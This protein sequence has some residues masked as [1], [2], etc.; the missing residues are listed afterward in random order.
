M[1]KFIEK[2]KALLEDKEKEIAIQIDDS[3]SV[4][5]LKS[6]DVQPLINKLYNEYGNG[7]YTQCIG[8]YIN[9]RIE[10]VKAFIA[11]M[12][13]G[14]TIVGI[15]PESSN[16]ELKRII[17]DN[18]ILH[19]LS[20]SE[21]KEKISH[22]DN[23]T[24]LDEE[25]ELEKA[26]CEMAV[27]QYDDIAVISY[28]SGTTG[29]FSKGV[30]ISFKNIEY[31][32]EQYKSI[33]KLNN[34]SKIITAL[35]LWHNYAMFACLTSSIF[36]DAVIFL[37][38]KWNL[39]KFVFW[40]KEYKA[41]VFPGS[42]Y[43]YLDIINSQNDLRDLKSLKICDSGGDSLPV[44]CIKK[45]ENMTGAI[46]TEGYGLT[47][48]TSL[49]HFNYS[50]KERKVGSI[51]RAIP[52]VKCKILDLNN[53]ELGND[54]WGILWINGPMVF[55][56]YVNHERLTKQVLRDG[57]F[58]TGDVV[59]KDEEGYYYIAGRYSD[60]KSLKQEE[61]VI[62]DI[63]NC[64]YQCDGIFRVH[65]RKKYDKEIKMVSYDMYIQL[66]SDGKREVVYDF[67]KKKMRGIVINNIFFTE[68]F[69]ITG[70]GKIKRNSLNF[71]K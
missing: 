63:E 39:E 62:R 29:E 32:S 49:T 51:G 61:G 70:T 23:V 44:E 14:Y 53:N 36:S 19:I 60:I 41:T 66:N 10:F 71:I 6:Y 48:T 35:P 34:T 50:A 64:L 21:Y 69:P 67:I 46:I 28:T 65:I 54:K 38:D 25:I 18:N 68:N 13:N 27:P 59:K 12:Y 56:G 9:N 31:V 52:G 1:V 37:M 16:E 20:V 4:I 17:E 26:K 42:P 15:N 40:C 11:I 2:V 8:I 22:L 3:K 43:M 5:R 45:F 7:G 47:E 55:S 33:Y 57:W 30:K 24:Y 58:N